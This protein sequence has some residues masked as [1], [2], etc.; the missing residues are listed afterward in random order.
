M[1]LAD[2][3]S[4]FCASLQVQNVATISYRYRA[5]TRRLNTDF[6]ETTSDV[7]HSLY[8]GSYKVETPRSMG[9]V[10]STWCTSCPATST[11]NTTST[12]T[13]ANPRCCKLSTH[14]STH[15]PVHRTSAVTASAW[16]VPF[17]DDMTFEVVPVFENTRRHLHLPDS[18]DGGTWQTTNPRAEITAIK[19]ATTPATRTSCHCVA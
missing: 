15:I 13:T 3:F 9:S 10:T 17:T 7:A 8:V 16:C 19:H 6:R 14:R 1:G 5:L 4:T 12:G 18:N 2:W 11:R